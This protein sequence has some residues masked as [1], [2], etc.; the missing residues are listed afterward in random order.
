MIDYMPDLHFAFCFRHCEFVRN[1]KC[2][3]CSQGHLS[4]PPFGPTMR[5]TVKIAPLLFIILLIAQFPVPGLPALSRKSLQSESAAQKPVTGQP[6]SHDLTAGTPEEFPIATNETLHYR[7]A[8]HSGDLLRLRLEQIGAELIIKVQDPSGK[9]AASTES[10]SGVLGPLDLSFVADSEGLYTVDVNADKTQPGGKFRLLADVRKPSAEDSARISAERAT[11]AAYR[12]FSKDTAADMRQSITA[13]DESSNQ[14]LALS[15]GYNQGICLLMSGL[16]SH[17]LSQNEKALDY[18]ARAMTAF[19]S[20]KNRRMQGYALSDMGVSY[21]DLGQPEKAMDSYQQAIEIMVEVKDRL[22]EARQLNNLSQIYAFQGDKLKAKELL[23]RAIPIFHEV[24]DRRAEAISRNVLGGIFDSLGEPENALESYQ[25]ALSLAEAEKDKRGKAQIMNNIGVVY[26]NLGDWNKALDYYNRAVPTLEEVGARAAE[27]NTLDNIGFVEVTSGR[28][29]EGLVYYNKALDLHR[30]TG[31]KRGEAVTLEDIGYANS[32]LGNTDTALDSYGKALDLARTTGNREREASTLNKIGFLYASL[33]Q[34]EKALDSFQKALPLAQSVGDR[35]KESESLQGVATVQRDSG[36]LSAAREKI[37]SAIGVIE[38]VRSGV[39]DRRLQA[40]F[41]ATKEGV[42]EFY[43]DLLM[44]LN[45]QDPAAGYAA[46]ALKASERA[47]ARSLLDTLIES[48]AD[49]RQGV[50]PKLLSDLRRLQAELNDKANKQ[51]LLGNDAASQQKRVELARQ[52]EDLANQYDR[53]NSEIRA[54]SPR[55][56]ALL[57]PRLLDASDIQ[58]QVLDSDSVL[59]EYFLGK[60]RSFLW[61]VTQNSLDSFVVPGREKLEA[62]AREIY[63]LQVARNKQVK[64]ETPEEKRARIADADSMYW[65]AAGRLSNDILG[66]AAA[67]LGGKRLLIVAQDALQYIPFAA[68]PEPNTAASTERQPLILSHE[69]VMLPSASVLAVLRSDVAGRKPPAKTVAVLADPVFSTDDPR[70]SE[71]RGARAG[72]QTVAR[73]RSLPGESS[74][75]L[76]PAAQ[77]SDAGLDRTRIPRLPFTHEEAEA[78]LSLVPRQDALGALG[79]DANLK[80]ATSP[81]LAGYRILHF[82]THGLINTHHPELSGIVLSLVN[83]RGEREDGFLRL[84]EIYNLKLPADL[85]VLSGCET[86]LGEQI[87]GEGLLGLTR[88][89]MYAGTPRI[90]VSLWDVSDRGT[91]G[92]MKSFYV[93]ML[94]KGVSASKA[95]Q[96]AQIEMFRSGSQSAP[97]FWAPFEIQGEW[98]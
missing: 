33:G 90:V 44:R 29:K 9:P 92:L 13:F 4:L 17:R 16:G 19:Q 56:A 20:G 51:S 62:E 30:A 40:S 52:T 79:F 73:E 87:K 68:L 26:S 93:A 14:W 75:G 12:L 37:E 81:E 28:V 84:N 47:R 5:L 27:A 38:D 57:Q 32:L 25:Q 96:I 65:A 70:V 42:Y 60:Q 6:A 10:L 98:R 43:V 97:Y 8:L 59:L 88:G 72:R 78:I 49:I 58:Q 2:K 11:Y 46:L 15:D 3:N 50:D 76:E 83:R 31:G 95:L 89:F 53:V 82:A 67:K 35:Y 23:S 45:Q 22:G 1:R 48:H 63:S 71:S 54:R 55:Y 18:Y 39:T 66:P 24:G 80:T 36:N 34:P 21:A 7:I 69:V 91:A 86:G 61:V 64:F 85:V 77:G 94:K 41:L 74:A